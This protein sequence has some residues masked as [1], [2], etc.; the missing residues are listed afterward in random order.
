MA[1]RADFRFIEYPVYRSS[2]LFGGGL[3]N[4]FPTINA[5]HIFSGDLLSAIPDNLAHRDRTFCYPRDGRHTA[6]LRSELR[7]RISTDG[8]FLWSSAFI[9]LSSLQSIV[10]VQKACRDCETHPKLLVSSK[11]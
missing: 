6:T 2:G 5:S 4:F 1:A 8:Y 10:E 7:S 3:Q 9:E 11:F